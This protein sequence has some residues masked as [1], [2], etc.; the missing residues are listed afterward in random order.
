MVWPVTWKRRAVTVA[1]WKRWR[2]CVRVI[3]RSRLGAVALG[4]PDLG[5]SVVFLVRLY[6]LTRL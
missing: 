1:G 3:M 6:R 5:L 2:K 4:R